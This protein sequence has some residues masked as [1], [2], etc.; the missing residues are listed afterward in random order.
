MWRYKILTVFGVNI[1]ASEGKEWKKYRKI[2]APAFSEVCPDRRQSPN[3]DSHC[4]K[5]I[6]LV[7]DETIRIMMD[8][9]DNVWG[10]RS[11]VVVNHCVDITLPVRVLWLIFCSCPN[12]F[13]RLR[14]SSLV[15]QVIYATF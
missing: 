5:N 8:M 6:K 4:Q 12:I 9:F 11:E 13:T 3:P 1:L 10:D 2:A 15:S 7:W 14:S